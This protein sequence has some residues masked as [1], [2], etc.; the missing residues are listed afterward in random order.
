M[1]EYFNLAL[2]GGNL[3]TDDFENLG[4]LFFFRATAWD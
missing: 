2:R 3:N 4:N 1:L